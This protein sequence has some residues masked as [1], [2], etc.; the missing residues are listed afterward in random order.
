MLDK[1]KGEEKCEEVHKIGR[2]KAK[3]TR[4]DLNPQQ[5]DPKSSA[6]SIELL[7]HRY[8]YST[9]VNKEDFPESLQMKHLIS[10]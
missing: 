6:L 8:D 9:H 1:I 10:K 7:V 5:L 2:E 4:Q 3:R